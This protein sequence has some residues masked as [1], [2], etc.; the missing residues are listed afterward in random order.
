MGVEASEAVTANQLVDIELKQM[1]HVSS[2]ELGLNVSIEGPTLCFRTGFRPNLITLN[3]SFCTLLLLLYFLFCNLLCC[4]VSSSLSH[5]ATTFP[6]G[7]SVD[8]M[9]I[10]IA[11]ISNS[12]GCQASQPLHQCKHQ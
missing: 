2:I 4:N 11:I 9:C 6:E 7:R 1:H 12:Y 3:R 10:A 5:T 8:R